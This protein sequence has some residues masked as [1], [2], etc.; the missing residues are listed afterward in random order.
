MEGVSG[1]GGWGVLYLSPRYFLDVKSDHS[2][3]FFH[4]LPRVSQWNFTNV[5]SVYLQRNE[6]KCININTKRLL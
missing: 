1:R 2:L 5:E 3:G 4:C 6:R